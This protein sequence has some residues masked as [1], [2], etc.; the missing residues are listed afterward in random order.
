MTSRLYRLNSSTSSLTVT[1]LSTFARNSLA[2]SSRATALA[3]WSA[4]GTLN[5]ADGTPVTEADIKINKYIIERVKQKYPAHGVIGEELSH[6][7]TAASLWIIDPIDGTHPFTLGL[8]VWTI[9]L[10][11]VVGD[12]VKVGVVYEPITDRL[13]SA[14][15]GGGAFCSDR[16]LDVAQTQTPDTLIIGS[17]FYPQQLPFTSGELYDRAVAAGL[18]T[19]HLHSTAYS[20]M[21][22]AT[23]NAAGAI[24]AHAK[25]WDIA[26]SLVILREAGVAVS[27]FDGTSIKLNTEFYDIAA[28]CPRHVDTIHTIMIA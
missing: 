25:S 12:V 11:Y 3:K 1:N 10:A 22:V 20:L 15:E 27:H 5:K 19:Y 23:G 21:L 26:A 16:R 13:Y 6:N 28:M 14:Q 17:K 24:T 2:P 4:V 9:S 18:K 7:E 8:P